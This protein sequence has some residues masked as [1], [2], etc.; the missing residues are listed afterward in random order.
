MTLE[1]T[2][3]KVFEIQEV[4]DL[5]RSPKG[6]TSIECQTDVGIVAFWATKSINSLRSLQKRTP[7]F[8]IRCGCRA[9][10]PNYP[11]HAWWVPDGTPIE[12][13]DERPQTAA[14][15]ATARPVITHGLATPAHTPATGT[16]TTA[17]GARPIIGGQTIGHRG[18]PASTV[19]PPTSAF[20]TLARDEPHE[21]SREVLREVPKPAPV[22]PPTPAAAP[23]P[24]APIQVRSAPVPVEAPRPVPVEAPR[25]APPPAPPAPVETRTVA[26]EPTDAADDAHVLYVV[27]ASKATIWDDEPQGKNL[28]YVPALFAYRGKTVREWLASEQ[29]A[30]ATHWLFLSPRY[31]FIEPDHP[32][33]RHEESWEPDAGPISDDA[34]RVQVASQRRWDD[35]IP[36]REFQTVFLWCDSNTYE[37]RV[38]AAFE[39]VGAK[40]VRLKA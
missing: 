5:I 32:V 7:P 13:I 20:R 31:G 37:D 2:E 1:A 30:L 27:S 6:H 8:R 26:A 3:V 21:D 4:G 24:P 39:K 11:T 40:V 23:E 18:G 36:L 10:L 25:P 14:T 33:A 28:S 22:D 34:L 38:R 29:R 16:A 15:I 9:P 12:F 19:V 17:T 35:Q